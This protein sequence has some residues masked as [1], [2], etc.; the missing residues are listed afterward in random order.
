MNAVD[1]NM[2]LYVR[3]P[4]DPIKQATTHA[5][6]SS[7]T[8]RVLIWQVAC[9]YLSASRKLNQVGFTIADA[10]K[11][12]QGIRDSWHTVLPNWDV[13]KTA[14]TLW[15]RYS[16]SIWDSLIV[17]ACLNASLERLYTEDFD[18]YPRNGTLEIVNPIDRG[19]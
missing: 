10:W 18:A 15:D 4:R 8:D 16:L 12:V 14:S 13:Q 17:A 7:L 5:L 6:V 9:E 2:L 19:P 1:T 11:D 3:D